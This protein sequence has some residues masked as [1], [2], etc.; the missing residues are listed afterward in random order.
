MPDTF[1][2]IPWIFQA[3]RTNGDVRV[4]CQANN[5]KTNGILR[6]E[7]GTA[8]NAGLR[9]NLR[10]SRNAQMLKDIRL[11]ML[12]G[13]WSD[14]CIRC[15]TEE[16]V[17]AHSRR[18]TEVENWD[19]SKEHAEK[20][21]HMNGSID[22]ADTPV[23]YYDLRFGNFCNFACRMCGPT[24]S[25]AWYEDWIK[26]TGT[27]VFHDNG[28]TEVTINDDLETGAFDWYKNESFWKQLESNIQNIEYIYF[29]GGEPMLIDRHYKFLQDCIDAGRASS[30]TI[31]YNTNMSTL[32]NRVIEM[33]KQFKRV[34]VGASI[35][36]YGDVFEYQRHG[37]NWDKTLKNLKKLDSLPDNVVS[38][39]AFTVTAYN[40]EHMVDFMKWCLQDSDFNNINHQ[41]KKPLITHHM[42]HY[43]EHVN[44]QALPK[45]Y[46]A[47]VTKKF[48][49]FK[50]WV[51]YNNFNETIIL[52]ADNV[53]DSVINYM[54]DDQ[55]STGQLSRFTYNLDNIRRQ[56]IK[57]VVPD[58]AQYL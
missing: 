36:G 28:G 11:N 13:R 5:S 17:G 40:V 14:E 56:S 53:V 37:G 18:M 3:A 42:A 41:D 26:M 16:Y 47:L 45:E 52:K 4:C 27:N 54:N 1:C 25:D 19:Y 43:P 30:I 23:R 50:S 2:P 35:D 38:W 57:D 7:D 9:D 29:A 58:L 12:E 8:Y 34:K 46:K 33:W 55:L 20:E 44:V 22:T 49:D 32:P 48:I 39:T 51:R 15:K 10:E 6:R 21:T 31:E 24:D